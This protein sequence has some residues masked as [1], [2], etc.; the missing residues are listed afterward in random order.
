MTDNSLFQESD[1]E[2]LCK[3]PPPPLAQAA[4]EVSRHIDFA[5]LDANETYREPL[6]Q[7]GLLPMVRSNGRVYALENCLHFYPVN[8]T[9]VPG[10]EKE[11]PA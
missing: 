1:P 10:R 6:V 4:V 2:A 7:T 5:L 9:A 11:Q 3:A 8:P